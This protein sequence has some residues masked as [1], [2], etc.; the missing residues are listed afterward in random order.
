MKSDGVVPIGLF[1]I[2]L[3]LLCFGI[4][5]N[6]DEMT[7]DEYLKGL[8]DGYEEF[9]STKLDLCKE[10]KLGVMTGTISNDFS[11]VKST[12]RYCSGYIDGYEKRRI[13]ELTN[14]INEE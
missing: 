1:V 12:K 14:S 11:E 6:D 3:A 5:V 4:F 13:E 7:S 2:V 9:N 10:Y 8:N